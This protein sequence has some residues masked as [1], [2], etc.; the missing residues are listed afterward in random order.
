MKIAL[1]IEFLPEAGGKLGGVTVA[2]HRLANG[3]VEAGH[4][5]SVV[6][7]SGN[8]SDASYEIVK[9][10]RSDRLNRWLGSKLGQVVY[11]LA[12]N[13]GAL[14]GDVD[15]WHFHGY[16]HFVLRP[17]RPRLR[18]L[19]GS[20]LR[21]M[22][23]TDNVLR[24]LLMGFNYLCEWVSVARADRTLCI[25]AETAEMYGLQHVV[26]NPFDPTLFRPGAKAEHPRIFYNGYWTGRKRGKFMYER[27]VEDILP[28][29]PGAELVMLCDKVPDHPRVRALRGISDQ[30]LAD[31]YASSWLFCY[32][33]IYEGFGMAYMEAMAA[34]T[35]IVTSQNPGADYVLEHGR[36]GAVVEDADFSKE[37]LR[38]L[39]D[40]DARRGLEL[41]GLERCQTFT[42]EAVTRQH[43]RHYQEV[44][45]RSRT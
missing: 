21:E 33:S 32:P 6:A 4:E 15:V 27:F 1:V 24:K 42:T 31:W 14:P 16:D 41:A 7:L 35:A 10:F 28:R 11:P 45:E 38:L 40:A 20:S 30:E 19:H 37:I 44:L 17:L 9:P 2:V 34:G 8:P 22:Q 26:D 43:L 12:L 39:Q 29:M 25:G 18:T 3:L 5:V 36:Y 13:F 23:A